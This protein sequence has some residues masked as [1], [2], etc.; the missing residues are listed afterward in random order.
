[1]EVMEET[2]KLHSGITIFT[3]TYNRG[4]ILG[5]L[6]ESLCR[7]TCKKFEW[8]IV[9]D[10]ST[11]DTRTLVEGWI[12]E[13]KIKI[14]YIYQVNAGKPSAHNTGVDHAK[15]QWF[16]CVDSDDY[17]T[18]DAI[19]KIMRQT[20]GLD[21]E[22][23]GLL[24][25]RIH[26]DGSSITSWKKGTLDASLC[27]AYRVYGL[28]GDTM[29]IYRTDIIRKHHFPRF[30]GEK[31]VPEAY[32]YDQL[33]QEGKL[34]IYAEPIYVCEYLEDGMTTSMK[35]VNRKNPRGYEVYIKQRLWLDDRLKDRFSDS[36]RY[37][38][39]K[40]VIKDG[41]MVRDAV[42]PVLTLFAWGPGTVLYYR[43][44]RSRMKDN[45]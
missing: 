39:I 30:D 12:L 42:Y 36:I 19:E 1:M 40:K 9:D 7:Q 14:R 13:G 33:D 11:D 35:T 37:V 34:R 16:S 4:Y 45:Q 17:L 38:A 8:L 32:L 44:Y 5:K 25:A 23:I 21:V 10:G 24:N 20:D 18:E 26:P 2:D 29:L 43:D 27:D 41:R 22:I 31:F 15:Y 3:P 28:L 6:Y